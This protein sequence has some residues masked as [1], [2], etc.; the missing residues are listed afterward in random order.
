MKKTSRFLTTLGILLG[1]HAFCA[2]QA[3]A[4]TEQDFSTSLENLNVQ[5]GK[6]SEQGPAKCE[7]ENK[8]YFDGD[9]LKISIFHGY[10]NFENMTLDGMYA[11]TLVRTLRQPCGP[12]IQACNF[13][14]TAKKQNA[15]RLQKTIDGTKVVINVLWTSLT[16]DNNIN[17]DPNGAYW[18]QE[19]LSR[20]VK[21]Q[22][23]TELS[24]SDVVIYSGHAR[25]GGG[26][27]FD[28]STLATLGF[29][30]LFKADVQPILRAMEQ[31]PSKLK[32]FAVLACDSDKYYRDA[33]MKANPKASL[34]L[35]K[36]E[37]TV[38]E[39]EQSLIGVVNSVLSK[40]CHQDFKEAMRAEVEAG[41]NITYIA[42]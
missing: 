9:T 18:K 37:F 40:R 11:D 24:Q 1:V 8:K 34:V 5:L 10:A 32:L 19:A 31:R 14:V 2:Y 41:D 42:R 30:Y 39:V 20:K 35:T 15:V 22:F 16:G 21:A 3:F 36:K 29:N 4:Y 12:N 6:L 26:M 13:K 17:S 23:Y 25:V 7:A 27:G 28:V 38:D 33:L